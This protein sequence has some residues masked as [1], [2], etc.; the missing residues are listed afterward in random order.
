MPPN[1]RSSISRAIRSRDRGLRTVSVATRSI[2]AGSVGAA[3][4]FSAIAAWA[5]PGRAKT[6]QST[7]IANRG[8]LTPNAAR[9][10]VTPPTLPAE[11]RGDDDN[12]SAG[13]NAALT[14]P[15]SPPDPGGQ[16][17][18]PGTQNNAPIPNFQNNPP[19]VVSGAT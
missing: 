19:S 9:Q 7:A 13:N 17:I 15:T 2:I 5:Q 10:P 6:T 3:A 4:V 8:A 14:P 16:T 1:Q 11:N 12:N 18:V